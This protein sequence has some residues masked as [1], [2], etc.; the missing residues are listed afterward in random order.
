MIEMPSS[1]GSVIFDLPIGLWALA[2]IL[3]FLILYL[4]RPR[5]KKLELPSLMFFIRYSGKS[6]VS[7]FLRAI[8]RDLLFFIQIVIV[9]ALL[10]I[11]SQPHMPTQVSVT[12]ENT[13]LVIDTSASMQAKE[14]GT[15]RLDKALAEANKLIGQK[16]TIVLA[17]EVPEL[18]IKDA[19]PQTAIQALK[20][21]RP[22][23]TGSRIGEAM[24]MAAEELEGN[25]RI[26]VLS[27]FDNTDG[28]SPTTAMNVIE[29][30]GKKVNLINLGKKKLDN[31]AIIDFVPGDPSSTAYI[32]NYG[33][34][35]ATIQLKVGEDRRQLNIPAGGLEPV[36]FKT[37]PGVNELSIETG[38]ALSQDDILRISGPPQDKIKVLLITNDKSKFLS[39]ALTSSPLIDL[40]IAEP[41][42]L[43]KFDSGAYD[44]YVIAN[45]KNSEVLPG[46]FPDLVQAARSGAGV[47][48][49][50]QEG[51]GTF[52]W[53]QLLP[54]ELTGEGSGGAVKVDQETTL[55]R[56]IQFGSLKWYATAKPTPGTLSLASTA[57]NSTIIALKPTGTGTIAYVG[58][59][60]TSDFKLQPD[61]P[62]FW[63]RLLKLLAKR[64]DV[65]DL[66]KKTGD[67]VAVPEGKTLSGPDGDTEGPIVLLERAGI[68]EIGD[69]TIAVNLL[70]A[71]ESALASH[72]IAE[73]VTDA[74]SLAKVTEERQLHLETWLLIAAAVFLL[75]ELL[76]L[77]VRGDV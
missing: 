53:G 5:P 48:I 55:T 70:D 44:I 18:L 76:F 9:L 64:Q 71:R 22:T 14:D 1:I 3:P 75:I 51:I 72:E 20:A 25:G 10:L 42:I 7:S 66:N 45:L 58:I 39:S 6:V 32:R 4:I 21:I 23:E 19:I 35:D 15:S 54:V 50:T 2:G 37:P 62:I 52:D 40:A 34:K 74:A 59:A 69:T 43:P 16:T 77:K 68:Y 27:D 49:Q 47:I 65:R 63:Q 41:P 33:G 17:K 46:T 11:P 38:D 30:K 24:L 12:A 67:T 73:A 29:T 61:Y 36:Q 57:D 28:V 26:V 8:L 60:E 13:V 31:I 56:D